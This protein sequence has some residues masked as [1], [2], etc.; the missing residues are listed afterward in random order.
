MDGTVLNSI[1]VAERIWSAWAIDHGIDLE[2]FLP[3]IHGVRSVDTIAALQLPGINPEIEAQR[4]TTTEIATADGI[5]EISGAAKFLRSLLPDRWAIVTSAPLALATARLKAAGLPLPSVLVT[6]EDVT[7]GKP[8]PECYLLAARKLGVN[9]RE[10]LVFEDAAVGILAAQAAGA[11]VIV[12]AETHLHPVEPA[13]T[14]IPAYEHLVADVDDEGFICVASA[15]RAP[16]QLSNT[17]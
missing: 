15:S 1:A 3:T 2:T 9:A 4:I 7:N 16:L 14:T 5:V 6:S 8:D 17:T 11:R 13:Y 10:C 12:V